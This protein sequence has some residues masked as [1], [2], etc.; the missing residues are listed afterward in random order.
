MKTNTCV[1]TVPRAAGAFVFGIVATGCGSPADAGS[2]TESKVGTIS[3][4]LF[5]TQA[6]F[7]FVSNGMVMYP[8]YA[9]SDMD[10]TLTA[11]NPSTGWFVVSIPGAVVSGDGGNVQV[12]AYGT[13]NERCTVASWGGSGSTVNINVHCHTPSGADANTS[14]VMHYVRRLGYDAYL[15]A[16]Q[17]SA[18]Q[19]T[20]AAEFNYNYSSSVSGQNN[21]VSRESAGNY[22]ARLPYMGS[23]GGA[24]QV[25]AYGA[26]TNYC[27]VSAWY[28]I[29]TPQTSQTGETDELVNVLCFNAA[30]APA[31]T[32]F[33]LY[34]TWGVTWD[35]GRGAFA[36]ANDPTSAS[37]R[38]SAAWTFNSGTGSS[39]GGPN[40]LVGC[41]GRQ[42]G[43]AA[44][45]SGVGAYMLWH[46]SMDPFHSAVHITAYGNDSNYCKVQSWSPDS[47]GVDVFTRCFNSA[48]A[49]ADSR[50][51]EIYATGESGCD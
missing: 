19:Y 38:P 14:F 7:A 50:Y 20:P 43:T 18:S 26:T 24:V 42:G 25:T 30:G 29:T 21:T 34:D 2:P 4:A 37:Y 32:M 46:S 35:S 31:D 11:T 13:G 39:T 15:W 5:E 9:M 28:S 48:G 36:W 27:K 22:T 44:T 40:M 49:P 33:T 12:V 8:N 47:S 41:T 3:E 1:S 45:R 6:A 16:N 51:V 23:S 10:A 17:P